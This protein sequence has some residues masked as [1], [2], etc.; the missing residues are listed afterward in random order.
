MWFTRPYWYQT[1]AFRGSSTSAR[2]S[3]MKAA[4]LQFAAVHPRS[5]AFM[6][7]FSE[8]PRQPSG[9][10]GDEMSRKPRASQPSTPDESM[11]IARLAAASPSAIRLSW[12]CPG[13]GHGQLAEMPYTR[14]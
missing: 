9:V 8:N 1:S 11:A 4:W 2:D 3:A 7:G 10:V 12:V 14:A 6:A 5:V 13:Y